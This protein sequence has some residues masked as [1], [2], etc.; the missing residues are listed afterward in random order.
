MKFTNKEDKKRMLLM[1]PY[2]DL[3]DFGELLNYIGG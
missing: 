3:L 1:R 2:A